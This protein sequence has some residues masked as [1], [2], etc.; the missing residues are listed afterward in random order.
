MMPPWPQRNH[1]MA[2]AAIAMAQRASFSA[3]AVQVRVRQERTTNGRVVRSTSA[4]SSA[5]SLRVLS[6]RVIGGRA[7]PIGTTTCASDV[8][9]ARCV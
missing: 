2:R 1:A 3:L 6:A 7:A 9:G 4:W 8:A 5:A